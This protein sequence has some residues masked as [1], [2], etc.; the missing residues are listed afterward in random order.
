MVR[1][2]AG[3]ARAPGPETPART[4]EPVSGQARLP[5]AASAPIRIDAETRADVRASERQKKG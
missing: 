3:C 1:R 2:A 5:R 4:P